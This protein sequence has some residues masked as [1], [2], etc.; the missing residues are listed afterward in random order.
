MPSLPQCV[1]FYDALVAQGQFTREEIPS[2]LRDCSR[3]KAKPPPNNTPE[4]NAAPP[5]H[6]PPIASKATLSQNQCTTTCV[7]CLTVKTPDT[8]LAQDE[9]LKECRREQREGKHGN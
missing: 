5:P 1:K 8:W 9:A 6:R 3:H 4:G 2:L 7:W